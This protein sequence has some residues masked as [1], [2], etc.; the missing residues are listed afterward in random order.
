MLPTFTELAGAQ[1]PAR[2][3]GVSFVASLTGKGTQKKHDYLYWEFHENGGRQA[4]RQG[5]W[6]AIRLQVAN[7]P[8]GPVELYDLSKDPA[9]SNN[10]AAKNP[11]KA[12]QLGRLMNESHIE[13]PLFPFIRLRE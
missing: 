7:N 12:E 6:K 10:V 9:E 13:S 4:I 8:T 1:T 5:D 2:I 3:D 11:E